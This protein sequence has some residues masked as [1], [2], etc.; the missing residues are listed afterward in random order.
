MLKC[1]LRPV[2]VLTFDDGTFMQYIVIK[3][4]KMIFDI[5]STLFL[6]TGLSVHP[7]TGEML[8]ISQSE[9]V[10]ELARLGV[11]IASHTHTHRDL[12]ALSI[13]EV[14]E[15]LIKSK[16]FIKKI[17]GI[18][19]AGFAYPYGRYNDLV[20]KYVLKHYKYARVYDF[21]INTELSD[22]STI[23]SIGVEALKV[24]TYLVYWLLK[25]RRTPNV[26]IK[27]K[28]LIV[29]VF[30]SPKA[31]IDLFVIVLAFMFIVFLKIFGGVLFLTLKDAI[32]TLSYGRC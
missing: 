3:L 12:T 17:T 11:E 18:I 2:V 13:E 28:M 24:I 5:T 7:H 9:K 8:L 19:P 30:H 25:M 23:S 16:L 21:K 15:E 29:L 20:R 14:E 22:L 4:A 26:E 6:I 31:F 27:R 1:K 32:N 10:K